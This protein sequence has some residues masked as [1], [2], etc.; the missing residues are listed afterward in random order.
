MAVIQLSLKC[1]DQKFGI[2][3][4]NRN[5]KGTVNLQLVLFTQNSTLVGALCVYVIVSLS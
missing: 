4:L 1:T 2:S 5:F 3:L